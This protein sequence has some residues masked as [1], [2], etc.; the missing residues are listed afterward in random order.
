M[1]HIEP[2][3]KPLG[4]LN[5]GHVI[6]GKR[7]EVLEAINQARRELADC[8]ADTCKEVAKVDLGENDRPTAILVLQKLR[9]GFGFLLRGD[10]AEVDRTINA[11]LMRESRPF[12]PL[13]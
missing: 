9:E 13:S 4:S 8:P 2:E 3:G 1:R 6:G 11:A 10:K 7:E 12:V 5:V